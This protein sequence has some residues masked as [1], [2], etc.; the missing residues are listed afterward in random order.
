MSRITSL[1][2]FKALIQAG[3]NNNE[4]SLGA[5]GKLSIPQP[6]AYLV[7]TNKRVV[8]V[9]CP[10]GKW[11]SLEGSVGWFV[12]DDEKEPDSLFLDATSDRIWKIY[13][14]L[15]V[16]RSDIVVEGWVK[17]TRGLDHCWLTR[18]HLLKWEKIAGWNQRG[19]GVKFLDGLSGIND[20][21]TFSL[22]AW[23]KADERLPGLS[24]IIEIAKDNFAISSVR[25]ENKNSGIISEWYSTGKVTIN[26]AT[27][28]EDVLLLSTEMAINYNEDLE[29]ATEIR[30]KK[31]G[32]FEIDFS[33]KVDLD[34]FCAKVE[35]G[36]GPM[37]LWLMET[38]SQPDF[39]R[40]RGVDM[41]NWDR[42]MLDI[43]PD[44]AYLTIP[45]KGCVNAAP[46]IASIQGVDNAGKTTITFDGVEI[47]G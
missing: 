34:A 27:D 45:G 33:Q 24:K 1:D 30:D 13:S 36:V 28:V 18:K 25:W 14:I 3:L 26:R 17:Q 23:H 32:A 2:D 20:A 38:E 39:K 21:S 12:N 43:G 31:M 4:K 5:F 44:Y 11:Q 46:R 15:D 10:L 29:E 9:G 6:K 42:V 22:K 35:A 41:H 16:E 7:E 8:D 19:M 40:F 47:F 37:K